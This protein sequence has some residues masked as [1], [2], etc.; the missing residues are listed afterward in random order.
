MADIWWGRAAA[1]MVVF[2]PSGGTRAALNHMCERNVCSHMF[3]SDEHHF[4]SQ[5]PV[6]LCVSSWGFLRLRTWAVWLNT[7]QAL[8]ILSAKFFQKYSAKG[9]LH[10]INVNL[11]RLEPVWQHRTVTV[12]LTSRQE[13]K[14][15]I[16]AFLLNTD[17]ITGIIFHTGSKNKVF[18]TQ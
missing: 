9:A 5:L 13:L 17:G 16:M 18:Y 4:C 11:A 7:T 12:L 8:S 15:A 1:S 14:D 2:L 10:F 6:G 3:A